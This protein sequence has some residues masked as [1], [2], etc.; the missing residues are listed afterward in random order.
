MAKIKQILAREILDSRGNPT[1]EAQVSLESGEIGI[2]IA[3][4]GASTGTN[5]AL[6]I[7][8]GDKLR[9]LGK[10]VLKAVENVNEIIAPE[11]IGKDAVRQESIDNLLIKLD[12]T[13]NKSKLGANTILSV[14]LAVAS[15]CAK[16]KKESL[17]GYLQECFLR[18]H[19]LLSSL[20]RG[21]QLL[22]VPLMNVINGGAHADN[23]LDIQEFMIVPHGAP[24]FKEALRYGAEI[25]HVLKKVLKQ[26][27]MQTAVGDE[28]G[29]APNLENNSVALEVI[30][31]AIED[32]GLKPG[33]DVS[34]ALDVASTEFYQ[35]GEYFLSS[36]NKKLGSDDFVRYLEGLAQSYPIVSIEDGLAEDDWS[37]WRMLTESLGSKVQL[38]GDDVFVTNP[39]IL[40]AA[41]E[42]GIANSL[43]VKLN[44]IGTLTETFMAMDIAKQANYSCIVSH[45]SGE[46][47]DTFIADLAVA[48][49]AGQIKTGSLSRSDRVAKYNRLLKIEEE[50]GDSACY[51]GRDV[52]K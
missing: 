8:D 43:L 3:P 26:R 17:Y 45:R 2:G 41:I 16:H 23:N 13:K 51:L 48:T 34:L 18:K 11:L 10:G 46:T 35:N 6:E 40:S 12:G 19:K 7:R 24:S 47:E 29:F 38:V 39:Q 28:G 31:T 25:F 4:S 32:V 22:P 30:L 44:Q 33:V 37:G 15:A 21:K 20:P 36:E 50:L 27:G 52:F 9:Y 14:S 49:A 5:E 1:L 42:E